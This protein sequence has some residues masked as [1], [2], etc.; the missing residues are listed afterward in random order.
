MTSSKT[1]ID[2]LKRTIGTA[3]HVDHG[4]TSLTA[5]LTGM[6]TDRLS[7]EKRR[8]VSIDLGFA[9]LDLDGGGK[10]VRAALVDV[11]GHEKFIKNM[12]AGTTGIDLVL[13]VVAADDGVM[14]QTREHFDIVRLL[15][16]DKALFVITKTDLATAARVEEVRGEV[17]ALVAGTPLEGSPTATFSAVTGEGLGDIKRSLLT[18]LLQERK[19]GK[20]GFFR[21]PID[22]SFA[23]KGF[24]TVVTGTVAGGGIKKG[25]EAIIFPSGVPVKVRGIQSTHIDTDIVRAGQRAALNISGAAHREI[26]RGFVLADPALEPFAKSKGRTRAVDCLFEFTGA[27]PVRKSLRNRLFKLHHQTDETLAAIQLHAKDE[28]VPGQ[29]AW[30][31]LILRKPLLMLRGDRFILRDP[32][33]NSTVGGGVVFV[34]YLSR[35]AARGV[36]R[37]A[38]PEKADAAAVADD[39]GA[40]KT[41]LAGRPAFERA[42]LALMLNLSAERLSSLVEG[43]NGAVT[44]GNYVADAGKAAGMERAITDYLSAF[45]AERPGESGAGEDGVLASVKNAFGGLTAHSAQGLF[46]ELLARL[47]AKGEVVRERGLVRLQ[48]HRAALSGVDASIEEA[49]LKLFSDSIRP[50]LPDELAGL[51]FKKDD[52]AR[53]LAYLQRNGVVVRIKEGAWISA[54]AM[55]G[56]RE[57]LTAYIKAHGVIRAGDF[58]D[59]LGCGR[60]L[61][62]EILEYFDRE[63]VTLRSGDDRTLR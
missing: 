53:V 40:L 54:A 24:G 7:E 35:E 23:S 51:G 33:V 6:D 12:L 4:K 2:T 44:L 36:T 13:F 63:R 1:P 62:I 57:K 56:A 8:G 49:L 28:P 45:H 26:R 46:R 22:R 34:H 25:D 5:A 19:S 16:V 38:F 20:T 18:L 31:R 21:L 29:K 17:L 55:D 30:G 58:R 15:G 60:K 41:L 37:T 11:P 39:A 59:I 50:P 3:G 47:A 14:P 9:H 61:A 32:S 43:F 42:A 10:T 52:V 27:F 48:A